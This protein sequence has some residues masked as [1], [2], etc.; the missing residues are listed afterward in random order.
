MLS[1]DQLKAQPALLRS[2]TSL[3][4]SEIE[5]LLAS[6]TL[7]WQAH[8]DSQEQKRKQPR[9]RQRGGGRKANLKS[10]ADK[11]LFILVYFKLYPLQSVQGVLFGMS[12][13]QVNEWLHRLTPVLHTALGY[14]SQLPSR[15]PASLESLLA[16]CDS[17]EFILDGTER[18]RQRPKDRQAQA[19]AYSGKKKSHTHKNN[20]IVN[21]DSQRVIYLSQTVS[22]KTHDKKLADQE[23][24]SFPA[25]AILDKDTGF[26]GYEPAGVI[27]FQ[28]KKSPEVKTS[29]PPISF[30]TSSSPRSA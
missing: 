12:Q 28:P 11:L 14:E 30:S 13:G 29:P 3:D 9:R 16:E 24:Y 21:T 10:L 19:E 15:E 17:L 1:Y 7:A 23:Q 22:G 4:P 2:L 6:F 26:Q 25:N 18:R 20:L 5:D 8:L 27:T